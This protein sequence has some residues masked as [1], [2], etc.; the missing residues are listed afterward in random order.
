MVVTMQYRDLTV[1]SHPAHVASLRSQFMETEAFHLLLTEGL[2]ETGS[3]SGDGFT[4]S[5]DL[6][7]PR[8]VTA[9]QGGETAARRVKRKTFQDQVRPRVPLHCPAVCR[10]TIEYLKNTPGLEFQQT[11]TNSE[12]NDP[13]D[14]KFLLK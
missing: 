5:G 10:Y 11:E 6:S 1:P 9:S 4:Q 7:Q 2:Y 12:K 13:K 14:A 3:D 8:Q